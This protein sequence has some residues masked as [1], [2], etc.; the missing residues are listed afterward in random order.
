MDN[1]KQ[2]AIFWV[3]TRQINIPPIHIDGID[4]RAV[5]VE[6]RGD[7]GV[8]VDRLL[9]REAQR[10]CRLRAGSRCRQH[11]SDG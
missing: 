4:R 10:V 2:V 6:T 9:D 7:L 1:I 8:G 3:K 5:R 11:Q